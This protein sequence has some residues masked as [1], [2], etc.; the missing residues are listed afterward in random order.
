[1]QTVLATPHAPSGNITWH[2]SARAEDRR[3]DSRAGTTL[4]LGPGGAL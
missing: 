3:R 2:G 1:M 4:C